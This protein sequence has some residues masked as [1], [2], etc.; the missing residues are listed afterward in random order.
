LITLYA[1]YRCWKGIE[2]IGNDAEPFV[3]AVAMF[4][5]GFVGLLISNVPYLV[6][7]ALTVWEAAAAPSSQLFMLVGTL[8]LL[9]IIL[10]YTVFVYW[11]FRGKVRPGEGY[12]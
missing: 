4:L 1:A 9:P 7:G 5:L 6:P 12:H 8:L 3:A 11:T 10:G 2:N